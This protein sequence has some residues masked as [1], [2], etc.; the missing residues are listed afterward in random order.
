MLIENT[1]YGIKNKIQIAIERIKQ[2]EPEEGYYVAFSGGKDSITVLDLVKKSNVKYDTHFNL[3]SVDPPELIQYIKKYYPDVIIHRPKKTM[4]QLI[5]ESGFP[6]TR[7]IRY[8]CEALKE[9]GGINREVITGIRWEE[10]VKRSKRKLVENCNKG[11]NKIYVNPIIDWS[12]KEIWEYINLNKL[13]YC[14]LYDEGY[15]R[16]G[17]IMCP[18]KGK[19]MM[20]DA[21]RWPL[22]YQAYL[23]T[24]DK[25]IKIRRDRGL[26]IYQET[27]EDFMKWWIKLNNRQDKKQNED[28]SLLF[29]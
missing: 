3:T 7:R 14:S 23:N 18:Q 13:P 10:S 6:P 29:E 27:K 11:Y 20:R 24:F 8:C 19:G 9:I 17:C 28:Q 22:F 25:C 4:F 26:L 2:F 1:L 16:I 5:L 21:Y 15:K 12:T